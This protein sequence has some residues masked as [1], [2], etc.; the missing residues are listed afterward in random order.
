MSIVEAPPVART[1]PA[2]RFVLHN[3]SWEEYGK[4]LEAIG[5]NHVRVTY[6]RGSLEL[7]SPLPIHERYKHFFSLFFTALSVETGIKIFGMGST[8]FRSQKAARGLEPDE[9]YYLQSAER[10][11]DLT[12]VDLAVDPPPDLAIEMD[13]TSSVL[14]RMEIYAALGIPEV[15]RCDGQ[16]LEAFCLGA[17]RGYLQTPNS[18]AFPFLPLNDLLELIQ[19][20]LAKA[21]DGEWF[22]VVQ[23]WLR[24]DVLPLR[25][26]SQPPSRK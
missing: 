25:E 17:E 23:E 11:R 7:M 15:W 4:F 22:Q 1:Q 10:V 21:N 12:L 5:E 24:E 8:T 19:H 18:M 20:G 9:C 26:A 3:V 2:Q 6:D 14:N 16:T 13:V